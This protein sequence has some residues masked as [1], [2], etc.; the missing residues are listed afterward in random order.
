MA[1][2]FNPDNFFKTITVKDISEKFPELA[3]HNYLEV[4]LNTVL[5]ER[6]YEIISKEYEDKKFQNI[7]EYFELEVDEIV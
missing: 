1:S 6:N 4:S 5:T 3:T 2:T 7:E